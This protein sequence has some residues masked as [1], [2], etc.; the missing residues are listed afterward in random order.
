[1]GALRRLLPHPD[2]TL[3]QPMV[4][5]SKNKFS[6][7]AIFRLAWGCFQNPVFTPSTPLFPVQ[8]DRLGP[9]R[10]KNGHPW[11]QARFTPM[12]PRAGSHIE[13]TGVRFKF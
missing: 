9:E 5:R 4:N 2:K 3:S 6:V 10:D 13:C 7:G 11:T 1:M 8:F 12:G